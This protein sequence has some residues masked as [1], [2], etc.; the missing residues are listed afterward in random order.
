MAAIGV[1]LQPADTDWTVMKQ[2]L[3]P[4]PKN[5]AIYAELYELYGQLYPGTREIAH[6]LARLQE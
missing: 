4:D 6:R 5:R 1:G 2:S 3:A